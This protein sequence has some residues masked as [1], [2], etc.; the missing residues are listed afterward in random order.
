MRLDGVTVTYGR[1]YPVLDSV[2]LEVRH[3][4]FIAI[5]GP[6]GGG[7]TTLLRTMLGLV[8]VS[9]G[10]VTVYG[11]P[12]AHLHDRAR[13]GYLRQRSQ[14][15]VEAPVTVREV[16]QAGRMPR[17]RWWGPLR[18][19]DH[20]AVSDAIARVGLAGR[21]GANMRDLSGGQQQ[22]VFLAKLLAGEPS[23]LL[24]DE[25]T[26]GVDARAQ[27][28]FAELLCELNQRIGV[29]IL[30]VSHEFGAVEA[31]VGR[32]VLV[33]GGIRFDGPPSALP[34]TWHDPSHDHVR[35]SSTHH[36]HHRDHQHHHTCASDESGDA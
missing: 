4:E 22:R 9:A 12:I 26:T 32:V 15:G 14:V 35:A 29:T 24:L 33:N 8:R 19:R 36:H 5:A 31:H 10:T 34:D 7:K 2:D 23:L 17:A 1:E 30:Y 21:E 20:A 27:H 13:I 25:P 18:V 16:V 28:D 6:N 3:G 11:E